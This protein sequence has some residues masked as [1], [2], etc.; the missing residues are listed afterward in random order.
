YFVSL[1]E[2][3]LYDPNSPFRNEEQYIPVLKEVTASSLLAEK[4]RLRYRSQLVMTLKN[5]VGQKAN[6]ITCTLAS[7]ESFS[8]WDLRSQYV[9]LLFSHPGWPACEAVTRRLES[10]P[11][12]NRALAMNSPTRTML[13][14]LTVYPDSDSEEWKAHLPDL[15]KQWLHADDR[16]KE[17]IQKQLYDLKTIPALY[18][19]DQDKKVIFKETSVE[20]VESFFSVSG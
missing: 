10:S 18:L 14:I 5:R 11:A 19:L 9:L 1:M 4:E 7:G 15:P 20:T 13:T 17:I 12:L 16:A 2:K 6:N 3:Y 8:L